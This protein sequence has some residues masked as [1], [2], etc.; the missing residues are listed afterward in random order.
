MCQNTINSHSQVRVMLLSQLAQGVMAVIAG[1]DGVGEADSIA[2][3]L[4]D[5][6]FVDGEPVRV[7]AR[8]PFGGEPLAVQIGFTRF[9]LR[10]AEANRVR[11]A[12]GA[13][14]P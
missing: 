13:D 1:V 9:A 3:R 2:R 4:Q 14:T 8:G 6:G 11:V 5:L 10:I 7:I 12:V